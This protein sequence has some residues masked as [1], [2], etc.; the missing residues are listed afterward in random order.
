MN[1]IT[2]LYVATTEHQWPFM[3]TFG[4]TLLETKKKLEKLIGNGQ[5]SLESAMKNTGVCI[6]RIEVNKMEFV[7]GFRKG[8][9]AEL[10]P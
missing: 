1:I 9:K 4:V 2:E 5:E 8:Q 10:V 7:E 6:A 3:E